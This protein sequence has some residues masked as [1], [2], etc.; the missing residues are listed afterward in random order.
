MSGSISDDDSDVRKLVRRQNRQI[1][2]LRRK[3]FVLQGAL[4]RTRGLV[5]CEIDDPLSSIF[6][7]E[8][9]F[10]ADAGQTV[11]SFA[12]ML[13]KLGMPPGEFLR[14]FLSM[15]K[16]VNVLFVKDFYQCWYQKGLIGLS[17]GVED[18]VR[19]LSDELVGKGD[20]ATIGTSA[21]GFGALLFGVLLNCSKIVAFGAQTAITPRIFKEFKS[22]DSRKIEIDFNSRFADIA[23]LLAEV[24]FRG[25]IHLHFAEGHRTDREAAER[26]AHFKAVCLHPHP[27]NNH[28]IAAWLKK[29]AR[30]DKVLASALS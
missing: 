16:P 25:E 10:V 19:V 6:P 21:G 5:A 8:K 14:S 9:R 29:E 23:K 4:L 13:T 17:G 3:I 7:I 26:L 12:G 1:E 20:V 15:E 11:I 22:V 24:D 27:T 2:Q 28:N 18:T 30:L